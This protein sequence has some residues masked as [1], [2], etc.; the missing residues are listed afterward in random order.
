V[1]VTAIHLTKTRVYGL[2]GKLE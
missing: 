2:D 1:V